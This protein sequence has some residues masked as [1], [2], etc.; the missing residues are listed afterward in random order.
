MHRVVPRVLVLVPFFFATAHAEGDPATGKRQFAQCAACHTVEADGATKVGP[1]L[2]G[3]I[4]RKAGS[5][6]GYD[7]SPAMKSA[8]FV[9]DEA[10][11]DTYITKPSVFIPGNKMAFLGVGKDDVR[12]NIIAYLKEATQ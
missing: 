9:W 3:I 12:A 5:N 2:H 10:R 11:L 4:G 6:A 1:N 7:Y 8:G